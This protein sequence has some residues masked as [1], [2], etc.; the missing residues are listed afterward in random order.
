MCSD[1]LTDEQRA[2]CDR[3]SQA[4][5]RP[6]K[7]EDWRWK[8]IRNWPRHTIESE[9]DGEA[10]KGEIYRCLNANWQE[11]QRFESDLINR[12]E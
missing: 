3:V 10:Y 1:N 6:D 5:N 2:A 8:R 11:I 4:L 7:K 9:P 12:I